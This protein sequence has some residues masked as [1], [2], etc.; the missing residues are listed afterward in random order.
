MSGGLVVAIDGPAG[1]G[2]STLARRLARVLGLPYLNTGLMYRALTLEALRTGLDLDDGDA[3][4]RAAAELRFG[5]TSTGDPP[6]LLID[7]RTPARE[8]TGPDVERHVSRVAA[9]PAVRSVLRA[10]Q[11]RLGE[12]GAV[13]EGRDIGAVVFADATVKLFLVAGEEERA[14]RR[15]RERAHADH[16][17]LARELRARDA[18]DE[19]VNPLVPAP[20]A[21]PLDT[22]GRDADEVLEEALAIVRSRTGGRG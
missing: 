6:R 16:P 10:E 12:A 3:L 9:H 8:L 15:A 4:A 20:D 13:V 18:L 22:S 2:K 14:H 7:G 21:V 19:Q 5:L 1:V 11:R 17:A